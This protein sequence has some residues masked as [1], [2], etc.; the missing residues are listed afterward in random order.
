MEVYLE[1]LAIYALTY[2]SSHFNQYFIDIVNE[3]SEHYPS[4][5]SALVGALALGIAYKKYKATKVTV[6][7]S[8]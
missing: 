5:T 8:E 7:E 2:V 1:Q 3:Y 6:S 4:A